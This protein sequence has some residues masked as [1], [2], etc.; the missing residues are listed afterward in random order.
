MCLKWKK[1]CVGLEQSL[2]QKWTEL[3]SHENSPKKKPSQVTALQFPYFLACRDLETSRTQ[4]IVLYWLQRPFLPNI[5]YTA[6]WL[7]CNQNIQWQRVLC[8]CLKKWLF[9]FVFDLLLDSPHYI[10]QVSCCRRVLHLLLTSCD[11]HLLLFSHV[12]RIIPL[13]TLLPFQERHT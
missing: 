12:Q 8:H 9:L 13:T 1:S 11:I 7:F 5:C 2:L 6:F 3:D 10:H 4:L